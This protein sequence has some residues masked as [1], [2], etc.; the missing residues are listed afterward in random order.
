LGLDGPNRKR[1]F[2]SFQL[3]PENKKQIVGANGDYLT[4]NFAAPDTFMGRNKRSL[5]KLSK[6]ILDWGKNRGSSRE[7]QGIMKKDYYKWGNTK[8]GKTEYYL[9]GCKDYFKKLI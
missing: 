7:I 6:T 5:E 1:E 8:S 4:A 9:K 3:H 2:P